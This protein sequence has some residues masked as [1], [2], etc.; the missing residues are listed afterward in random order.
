VLLLWVWVVSV[1]LALVVLGAVAYGVMGAFV[2]LRREVEGAQ[3][4]IQPVLRQLQAAAARAESVT[5]R[6]TNTP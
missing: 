5:A 6:Q 4:D 2:R 3:R 1:V